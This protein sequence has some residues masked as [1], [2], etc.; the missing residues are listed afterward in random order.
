MT[1]GQG[2]TE[3]KGLNFVKI[4]SIT[5]PVIALICDLLVNENI[6]NGTGA[7]I[8]GLIATS[9]ASAGYSASRGKVKAAQSITGQLE[10]LKKKRVKPK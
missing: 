3:H 9:L 6:V 8:A 1:E 5:L 4:L 10:D 2:T 7:V